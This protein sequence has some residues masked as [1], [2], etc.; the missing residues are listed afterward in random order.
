MLNVPSREQVYS[1]DDCAEWPVPIAQWTAADGTPRGVYVRALT[2]KE[3]MLAERKATDKDGKVN[4][5][6]LVANEVA[7]GV[8][9][10]AGLTPDSLLGWNADVV[11]VIHDRIL[12]LGGLSGAVVAA[13]LQRLAGGPPPEPGG[14]ASSADAGA[15]DL[16]G[17]AGAAAVAGDGDADQP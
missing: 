10:P 9:R 5:W 16:G 7:A 1:L 15:D 8:T 3:R 14:V 12:S 6:L 13:E 11:L 4:A 17:D 2:F